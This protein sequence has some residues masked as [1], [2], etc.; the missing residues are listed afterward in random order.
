MRRLGHLIAR[1]TLGVARTLVLT[2]VG[3]TLMSATA[4]AAQTR[5]P[6]GTIVSDRPGLGDGSWVLAPG[7]LQAELGITRSD[8]GA[9]SIGDGSALVRIG[10][11][12]LELRL[13]LPTLSYAP[14][15]VINQTG[16]GDLGLGTKIGL[17]RSS[18]WSS[19]IV[20]GVSL[21]TG[22]AGFGSDETGA[23][24]SLLVET[25]LTDLIGLAVNAGYGATFDEFGDG[26]V[27]LIVTP[28][29]P[30]GTNLSG[31]AGWAGYFGTGEFSTDQNFIEAG[32]AGTRGANLQWDVNSG[33]DVSTDSWFVGFGLAIRRR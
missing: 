32:I 11:A 19:S 9:I 1:S 30:L 28:G 31:Y 14:D 17:S 29:F 27:S 3:A 2:G 20:A 33:F 10:F 8:L 7:V 18:T 4:T 22:S 16:V 24:A 26:V 13:T 5:D 6:A 21:P 12:P 23:S 15:A 25:G